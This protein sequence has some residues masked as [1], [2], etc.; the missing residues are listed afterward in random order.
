M[1]LS[2]I[3][4]DQLRA[5]DIVADAPL[6]AVDA[7]EVLVYFLRHF[8]DFSASKSWMLDPTARRLDLALT[9][10]QNGEVADLATGLSLI[11]AFFEAEVHQQ[12]AIESA[13][14]TLQYASTRAQIVVLTNLPHMA[15]DGRIANLLGHSIPYPVVTNT[16][17]KGAALAAL[18]ARTSGP[19]LF[20]DDSDVQLQSAAKGAPAVRRLQLI[21][22]DYA[23]AALPRS[24]AAEEVALDWDAGRRWITA[25]LG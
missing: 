6:I 15:R 11:D 21:G 7:D 9:H 24:D 22:C 10:T 23:A 19:T 12:V 16:G 25:A 5:L 14:E 13:A 3:T 2:D 20:I 8:R 17:G 1:T 4:H 18:S